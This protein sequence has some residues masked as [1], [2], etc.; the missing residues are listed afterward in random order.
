MGDG[1]PATAAVLG[2]VGAVAVGRDG[3]LY[4]ADMYY[5]ISRLRRIGTDG[6]IVTVA[7]G[8]DD[9]RFGYLGPALGAGL[10]SINGIAAGL[11]GCLYLC[12]GNV[13]RIDRI[14]RSMPGFKEGESLIP[15]ADGSAIYGF[16]AAGR[17]L[18]TRNALTGA[19]IYTFHYDSAEI[20]RAHV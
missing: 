19:V 18:E 16:T 13:R 6:I 3:T 20:G 11:D 1:G 5:N 12:D 8:G 10:G 7:G 14:E 17:H 2:W 9:L 15:A 4:F